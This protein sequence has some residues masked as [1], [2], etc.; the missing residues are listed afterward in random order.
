M[1]FVMKFVME[2]GTFVCRSGD[3]IPIPPDVEE[4]PRW[5]GS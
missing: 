1:K 5:I 2:G 4:K 3:R